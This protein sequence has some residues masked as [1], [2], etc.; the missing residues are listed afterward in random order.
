MGTNYFWIP[1]PEARLS[2]VT[3]LR[4]ALHDY[5]RILETDAVSASGWRNSTIYEMVDQIDNLRKI[6]V[7][8][9][10]KSHGWQYL[11]ALHPHNAGYLYYDCNFDSFCS[12]LQTGQII[13][14]YG[15]ALSYQDFME[16]LQSV[17]GAQQHLNN[18][19]WQS[20]R[21]GYLRKDGYDWCSSTFR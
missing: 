5:L 9:G 13:T 2:A 19:E 10:K 6:V 3:D 7:H 21:Y 20:E 18:S 14:E 12:F 1:S 17:S 16:R 8:I 4:S 15:D 11:I